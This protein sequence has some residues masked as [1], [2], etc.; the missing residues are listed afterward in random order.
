MTEITGHEVLNESLRQPG[1]GS[2]IRE[3]AERAVREETERA[4]ASAH[5]LAAR[6][7]RIVDRWLEGATQ[8]QIAD[9]LGIDRRGLVAEDVWWLRGRGV[10]LPKR[11]PGN[12]GPRSEDERA[13]VLATLRA[14]AT[15]LGRAPTLTEVRRGD[16]PLSRNGVLRLFGTW[17]AALAAAGLDPRPAGRPRSRKAA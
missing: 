3:T 11:K 8:Q 16:S 7:L 17:N 14:W 5:E 6:R 13:H 2:S 10:A 15:E 4:I 1:D 12:G 9:D